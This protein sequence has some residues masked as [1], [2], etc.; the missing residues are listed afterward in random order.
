[1]RSAKVAASQPVSQSVSQS[2]PIDVVTLIIRVRSSQ[3]MLRD[4]FVT[5]IILV[6]ELMKNDHLMRFGSKALFEFIYCKTNRSLD[7]LDFV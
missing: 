7:R 4:S 1:M 6:S 5:S 2:P 3:S